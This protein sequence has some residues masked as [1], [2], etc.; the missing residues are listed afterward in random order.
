MRPFRRPAPSGHDLRRISSLPTAHRD[1][2]RER[3]AHAHLARDPDLPTV[4]FDELPTQGQSQ[5]C[6]LGFLVRR[7]DLPELLKH[8]LLIRRG[9]GD[10][11]GAR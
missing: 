7:P 5:S 11:G 2:E 8:R 10:P 9:D 1:R 4:E 3:R 6:P